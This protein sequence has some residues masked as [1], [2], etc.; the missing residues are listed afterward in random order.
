MS[1]F[2]YLTPSLSILFLVWT[3]G[4]CYN[5]ATANLVENVAH[6]F[7]DFLPS[8]KGPS[9]GSASATLNDY[10]LTNISRE[11]FDLMRRSDN[12]LD[13]YKYGKLIGGAICR[14]NNESRVVLQLKASKIEDYT[15]NSD[16]ISCKLSEHRS[17]YCSWIGT[18][19]NG[20][21]GRTVAVACFNSK[22]LSKQEQLEMGKI[23]YCSE[24]RYADSQN[25]RLP[26][27]SRF[28]RWD[29]CFYAYQPSTVNRT[30]P[31][32]LSFM[33]DPN[34][35]MPLNP[36]GRTGISGQGMLRKLGE[37]RIEILVIM[38]DTVKPKQILL[39]PLKKKI[40]KE[41]PLPTF[42]EPYNDLDFDHC[43]NDPSAEEYFYGLTKRADRRICTLEKFRNALKSRR[44]IYHDYLPHP[45]ATDNA[46]VHATVWIRA[47]VQSGNLD[48]PLS[49]Q[50]GS[51]KA[52]CRLSSTDNAWVSSTIYI[53]AI[54]QEHCF[55]NVASTDRSNRA[56][57][58]W[59]RLISTDIVPMKDLIDTIFQ[60]L[61]KGV[62]PK[63]F[64]K[65]DVHQKKILPTVWWSV[66]GIIHYSLLKPGEIV[67]AQTYCNELEKMHEKLQRVRLGL[68]NRKGPILLHDNARPHI[69]KMTVQKLYHTGYE[70]LP[71][72]PY[73]A[74]LSPTDYHIFKHLEHFLQGKQFKNYEEAKTAFEEFIASKASDFYATGINTLVSRW[75]KCIGHEGSY[76]D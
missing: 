67:T 3:E 7:K 57:H 26:I 52:I 73:S 40:E 44:R 10:S 9:D 64:P 61:D 74:D 2:A 25:Y 65:P 69:S 4:Y 47:C 60:G 71:H 58:A 63:R 49:Q 51:F 21:P 28:S 29:E 23:N 66:T 19:E 31:F 41:G 43:E 24:L 76:L 16:E 33:Y 8:P 27:P 6:G 17:I 72:P 39:S 20:K 50:E 62:S 15:D 68:V 5:E 22:E 48:L 42:C 54:D 53:V 55:S 14:H 1:L 36:E 18:V 32:L 38:R 34:F 45:L 30:V 13:V 12:C 37:N 75:Q 59:K 70:T 35:G 46:W 56:Q 11:V